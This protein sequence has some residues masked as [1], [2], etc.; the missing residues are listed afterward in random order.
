MSLQYFFVIEIRTIKTVWTDHIHDKITQVI[1][2]GNATFAA[3]LR[4]E[5]WE[6]S[7]FARRGARRHP[8]KNL[9]PPFCFHK[10]SQTWRRSPHLII[11][12]E[13]NSKK[14]IFYTIF[15]EIKFRTRNKKLT[16]H[17]PV[18]NKCGFIKRCNDFEPFYYF[19]ER[20]SLWGKVD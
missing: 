19:R 15:S 18:T 9:L 7:L 3:E 17:V 11:K 20:V 6:I 13:S 4:T 5:W 1:H 2:P 12:D 8:L 10:S 14:A 16:D